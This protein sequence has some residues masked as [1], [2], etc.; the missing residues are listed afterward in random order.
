MTPLLLLP[1]VAETVEGRAEIYLDGGVRSG[2]DVAAAVALGAR[3]A[4]IGRPYLYAL[5]AGGEPGVD[6]LLRILGDDYRRTLQ[7]L[8]VAR[9]AELS[10]DFASLDPKPIAARPDASTRNPT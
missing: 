8:G 5:M 6:H 10:P 2:A 4:F 3:A 7:L 9:T 1:E